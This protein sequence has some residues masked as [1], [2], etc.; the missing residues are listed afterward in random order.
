MNVI[1]EKWDLPLI[2]SVPGY[3]GKLQKLARISL[4][5]LLHRVNPVQPDDIFLLFQA[6]FQKIIPGRTIFFISIVNIPGPSIPYGSD[7]PV[8]KGKLF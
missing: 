2:T 7:G 1:E 6:F 5:V 3:H 8:V 4:Q